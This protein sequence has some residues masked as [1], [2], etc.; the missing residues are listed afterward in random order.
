MV[1]PVAIIPARAGSKRFPRKNIAHLRGKPLI[2][3]TIQAAIDSDLFEQTIVST[4]DMEIAEISE[5]AGASV[6]FLRPDEYASDHARIIDV[7][8]YM[9]KVLEEAGKAFDTVVVLQPTCPLRTE[10]DIRGAWDLFLASKADFLLSITDFDH[11][12]FWAME[13]IANGRLRPYWGKEFLKRSQ[14]LPRLFR[15]NGAIAIANVKTLREEG[16]FYGKD[17]VGFWMP[18]NRSLDIDEPGDLRLAE[19]MLQKDSEG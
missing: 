14:D 15:P 5:G 6:P 13:S 9:L 8:L 4:E 3:Y 12:P 18:R 1:K 2:T 17:L 7:C 16:T 11:P 10:R 19:Y